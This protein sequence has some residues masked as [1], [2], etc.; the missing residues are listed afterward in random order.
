MITGVLCILLGEA[1]IIA[2]GC[3]TGWFAIFF[4]FQATA[5]W[6][7]EEP[8]LASATATNTSTTGATFRAGSPESRPGPLAGNRS[9]DPVRRCGSMAV[10]A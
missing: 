9:Q 7:W 8:H 6:F 10:S 1:A 4:A 2:S 5:I 3:T